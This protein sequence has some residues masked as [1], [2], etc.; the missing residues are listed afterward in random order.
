MQP[1]HVHALVAAGEVVLDADDDDG[2]PTRKQGN[3]EFYTDV[4]RA[5][6]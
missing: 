3:L 1:E 4:R 2:V 6:M 5:S